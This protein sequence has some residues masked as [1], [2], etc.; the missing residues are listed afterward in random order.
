MVSTMQ[1]MQMAEIAIT[2]NATHISIRRRFHRFNVATVFYGEQKED[3][4]VRQISELLKT[5][6]GCKELEKY[7]LKDC[8]LTYRL[9]KDILGY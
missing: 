4:D 8:E 9:G 5:E 3:F 6:Q 7:N 1:N 2:N